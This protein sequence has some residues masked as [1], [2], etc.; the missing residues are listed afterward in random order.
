MRKHFLKQDTCWFYKSWTFNNKTSYKSKLCDN[1]RYTRTLN[2]VYWWKF[3]YLWQSIELFFICTFS[4]SFTQL[5]IFFLFCLLFLIYL[6][7][8]FFIKCSVFKC[9]C[10]FFPYISTRIWRFRFFSYV[11]RTFSVRRGIIASWYT[12]ISVIFAWPIRFFYLCICC[13]FLCT[14]FNYE[15]YVAVE[16]LMAWSGRN[17]NYGRRWWRWWWYN[18]VFNCTHVILNFDKWL[19]WIFETAFSSGNWLH[20]SE[21]CFH[22]NRNVC[23]L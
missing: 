5:Y 9:V 22:F 4:R 10:C 11:R 18:Q 8:K 3:Y 12:R 17:F 1:R 16:I 15:C 2:I 21:A 20:I 23:S 6:N 14:I 7:I 19:F 13:L